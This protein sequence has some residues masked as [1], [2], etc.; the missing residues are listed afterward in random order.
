MLN[1]LTSKISLCSVV[2]HGLCNQL[3]WCIVVCNLLGVANGLGRVLVGSYPS[4]LNYTWLVSNP[5]IHGLDT[6]DINATC[7]FMS[8]TWHEPWIV[9]LGQFRR[10][11]RG[12][13]RKGFRLRSSSSSTG[14]TVVRGGGS[15]LGGAQAAGKAWWQRE[16]GVHIW[17][18]LDGWQEE[19]FD[20]SCCWCWQ[21]GWHWTGGSLTRVDHRR[22][23]RGLGLGWGRKKRRR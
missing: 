12:G 3:C 11:W 15:D 2:K 19:L 6:V 4:W 7:R 5:W 23:I 21:R 10:S 20:S 14:L 8:Q 17:E 16:E 1:D 22:L 9:I 18:E 13:G